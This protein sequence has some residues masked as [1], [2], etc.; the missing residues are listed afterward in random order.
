MHQDRIS[1]SSSLCWLPTKAFRPYRVL[2][3]VGLVDDF[4][5]SSLSF[6]HTRCAALLGPQLIVFDPESPK[7][8]SSA[9]I[10]PPSSSTLQSRFTS[11]DIAASSPRDDLIFAGTARGNAILY[12]SRPDGQLDEVY[13]A[14]LNSS[15]SSGYDVS[16][17]N[18]TVG[19]SSIA[20]SEHL[21]H[22]GLYGSSCGAV[23]LID[24]RVRPGTQPSGRCAFPTSDR[25]CSV[26]WNASGAIFAVGCND[27]A[28]KIYSLANMSTPL[29]SLDEVH[30]QGA[31][32]AIDFHPTNPFELCTGG[33]VGNGLIAVHN[34]VSSVSALSNRDVTDNEVVSDAAPRSSRSIRSLSAGA[35]G[36]PEAGLCGG[37]EHIASTRS[38]VCQVKYSADG[39][40]IISTHGF[41]A[42]DL[43]RISLPSS[44]T[45]TVLQGVVEWPSHGIHGGHKSSCVPPHDEVI[46]AKKHAIQLW[47]IRRSCRGRDTS[48]PPSSF[49]DEHSP[50]RRGGAAPLA[51]L[52]R[53]EVNALSE[54]ARTFLER[55]GA[56]ECHMIRRGSPN[57]SSQPSRGSSGD[58][59]R[60]DA[61]M[62]GDGTAPKRLESVLVLEGH[63][64]RPLHLC[65]QRGP[66][67]VFATAAGGDDCTI[68]FWRMFCP[69][70]APTSGTAAALLA[71][72]AD[73]YTRQTHHEVLNQLES[74]R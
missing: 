66:S 24:V 49:D 6:G 4:Y 74:I 45:G 14:S 3:A 46:T 7:Q 50:D 54:T 10:Q 13:N 19:I 26:A 29:C 11:V 36:L 12:A 62:G 20:S 72:N 30:Q 16:M 27:S 43:P 15:S 23:S 60:V 9:S 1:S 41:R 2:D 57:E 73:R 21:P 67:G 18:A 58:D 61:M 17:T 33:G 5:T 44:V 59:D 52:N 56:G 70:V 64:A 25:V 8:F 68:R 69:A 40:H 31:V 34:I 53:C 42:S 71:E 63:T 22:L 55:G 35:R 39:Q 37:L 32:R 48:P 28:V 47:R 38:Q 65:R 51:E